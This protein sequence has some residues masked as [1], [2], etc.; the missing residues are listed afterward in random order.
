MAKG[1]FIQNLL[2]AYEAYLSRNKLIDFAGLLP[3]TNDQLNPNAIYLTS[4]HLKLSFVEQEMLYRL[5][6]NHRIILP[7]EVAF[8][9]DHSEFPVE[10][11][12]FF[13][14]TSVIT[15]VREV[16]RRLAENQ[17]AWDQV[18]V[19]TS[20]YMGYA[21]VVYAMAS[22]WGVACTFSKGISLQYTK[23]GRAAL[24]YLE[25]IES[26]FII[27]HLLKAIK[28][29]LINLQTANVKVSRGSLIGVMERS[30]IGWGRK[31]YATWMETVI[32][33]Q[34]LLNAQLTEKDLIMQETKLVLLPFFEHLFANL[35]EGDLFTPKLI[36]AGLVDFLQ[37]Y[38]MFHSQE[39]QQI[40]Q[41][42]DELIPVMSWGSTKTMSMTLAIQ[43]V[44]AELEQLC[45]NTTSIP[46]EGKLHISSLQDGGQSGRPYTYIVGMDE[47][48]W[49]V[50]TRQ[51]P[52][53]L[54]EERLK[55]SSHLATSSQTSTWLN[56][57]RL[58]RLGKI[59][60]GCT[61][62]FASY[63]IAENREMNPAY[64]LLQLFRRKVRQPEAD[65]AALFTYL[66]KPVGYNSP[67]AAGVQLDE[68]DAWLHYLITPQLQ[69]MQGKDL[70]LSAYLHLAEGE[71]ASESR[72]QISLSA[73]DGIVDTSQ[74]PI[75]YVS[76][77]DASISISKLELFG[78]CPLLFFYQEILGIRAKDAPVYERAQWL[79]AKQ[80]GSLVHTVFY[81]YYTEILAR[82]GNTNQMIQDVL[83]LQKLT[84]EVI[85]EYTQQIPAPSAHIWHKECESI[86]KD[87]KIFYANEQNRTSTPK[88][89]ELKLHQ[90]EGLFHLELS[91]QLTLPIKGYVDRVDQIGPHQYKILDYKSGST[92][93]YKANEF[94]S[95]GTQM[96][97]AL[98]AA[99]TEQY[100]RKS[101][102]DPEA[103]V[104]ESAY[105]FPTERGMGSE[106]VRIQNRK[107]DLAKLI[108][109][110][111]DAMKEGVF[112]PTKDPLNCNWCDYQ[113]VCDGQAEQMKQ[114]LKRDV[115][116][117]AQRLASLREVNRYA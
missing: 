15:E 71:K 62:S 116:A 36:I 37:T 51:D 69:I 50:S 18:E 12:E 97:H 109:H 49:S 72:S 74:H 112:L 4:T 57:E 19:I 84:E 32:N 27:D 22:Q 68:S 13:H 23:I 3:L 59:R 70:L 53:L 56:T 82:V 78:R 81:H 96:Q 7:A 25:W 113:G 21:P 40:F 9:D 24:L 64:E 35:P 94:F 77:P 75:D 102:I 34:E 88:Y 63:D 47:E 114:T 8:I 52:I 117:N 10:A 92:K 28:Q 86:R 45:T 76:G 100:L 6:A 5:A 26:G 110:M 101:G 46:A 107:Q 54:D 66:L 39:E 16:F 41:A 85:N 103:I 91:E 1:H 61:L 14:A 48:N 111:L 79:D 43:Y 31:R 106:V 73:Y 98:Y 89:L 99:A 29:G 87:V 58:S 105:V 2:T 95:G 115:E 67:M 93:K 30:G 80:K 108:Q 44:R 60:E 55:L 38:V 42:F 17:F 65:Y 83:L 90:E 104:V 20:D 33:Q 11:V